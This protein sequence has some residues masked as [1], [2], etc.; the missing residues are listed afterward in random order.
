MTQDEDVCDS[1]VQMQEKRNQLTRV[2]VTKTSY[3][4][5][6]EDEGEQSLVGYVQAV[7]NERVPIG[8]L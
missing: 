8:P 3:Q 5:V 6:T 1:E 2:V 7:T 4:D